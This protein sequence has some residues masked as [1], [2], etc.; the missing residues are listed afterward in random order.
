VELFRTLV[1]KK[2]FIVIFTSIVTLCAVVFAYMKI[3]VYEV[4]SNVKIGYIGKDLLG[5][6]NTIN[7][8]LRIVF[9][10]DDK[11][12][13]K[14]IITSNVTSISVNKKVQNFLEIKTEASSNEK[15]LDKN[16]EVVEYLQNMHKRK[17]ENFKKE[18]KNQIEDIK[19][20]LRY[21]DTIE[22][23][24]TNREIEKLKMQKMAKIA[25][26]IEFLIKFKIPMIE[27]K[28]D[29]HEEKLAKYNNTIDDLIQSINGSEISNLVIS[30]QM[31]NYQ[32]MI[33]AINNKI[34]DLSL[35]K[36]NI[37]KEV[38]PSL[39]RSKENIKKDSIKGLERK[40]NITL[41]DK[42]VR[43]QKNIENLS[44]QM[45]RE[46]IENSKVVGDYILYD[47]PIKPKKKLIVV[48]AF[49][50]GLILSIFLVF[51]MEFIQNIK[52]KEE[53]K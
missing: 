22:I 11:S 13:S 32:N 51:F 23:P 24:N 6:P 16:R 28:I 50:T 27:I 37:I 45:S 5:E 20:Q 21:V 12:S 2:W 15:A 38:L 40:I 33:L 41:R 47:Y 49:V 44:Y 31:I 30:I 18:I 1:K 7:K 25:E 35:E 14:D 3:S 39:V 52:R 8:E 26:K 4:K 53:V 17:I 9:N 43:L 19:R 48:V 29:N 10:V 42:K 46:N 36:E 34:S